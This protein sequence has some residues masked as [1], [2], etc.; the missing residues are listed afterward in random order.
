MMSRQSGVGK[1]D[2]SQRLNFVAW[3]VKWQ[4]DKMPWLKMRPI[5]MTKGCGKVDEMMSRHNS[6]GKVESLNADTLD[7]MTDRQNVVAPRSFTGL[8]ASR[9]DGLGNRMTLTG[10][11][12]PRT[13]DVPKMTGNPY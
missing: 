6:I 5:L 9:C 12:P 10:C 2:L 13:T 4:V 11:S 3:L 7:E 8:A 1:M